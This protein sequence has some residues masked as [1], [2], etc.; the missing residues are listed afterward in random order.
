ME[1]IHIAGI[2]I[3]ERAEKSAEVQEILTRY[4]CSI[5]TRLGIHITGEE[6]AQEGGLMLLELCGA[7]EEFERM[8]TK[9]KSIE[10]IHI[11]RMLF[12]KGEAA[13]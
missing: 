6:A 10:G 9:L 1:S 5:K 11:Q 12:P 2:Y 4:G 13:K 8:I 7:P 3:P